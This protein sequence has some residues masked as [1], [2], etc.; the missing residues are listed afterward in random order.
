MDEELYRKSLWHHKPLHDFWQ[1]GRGI[2]SRLAKYGIEDMYD[3]AHID[4]RLLY[5]DERPF[6]RISGKG[7]DP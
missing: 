6:C 3:I 4:E 5:K 7:V 2:E 1:V